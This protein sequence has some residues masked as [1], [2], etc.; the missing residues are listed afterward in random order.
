MPHILSSQDSAYLWYFNDKFS[1]I[2]LYG[3]WSK[4]QKRLRRPNL[5]KASIGKYVP[6]KR[7]KTGKPRGHGESVQ[8]VPSTAI[9]RRISLICMNA[10]WIW[11]VWGVFSDCCH[12]K[13]VEVLSTQQNKQYSY[14]DQSISP[15]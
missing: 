11:Q 3:T 7:A 15:G 12:E 6:G 10:T 13:L 14:N 4:A 8:A 9:L 2:F 1:K 5:Y